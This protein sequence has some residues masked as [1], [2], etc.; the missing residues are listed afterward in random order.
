[1]KF[2]S[3]EINNERMLLSMNSRV[4]LIRM[5]KKMTN[6]QWSTLDEN[7]AP[8]QWNTSVPIEL[9]KGITFGGINRS[10]RTLKF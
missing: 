1:M 4:P 3:F 5:Y 8:V 2:A 9:G 7:G 6:M 10:Y